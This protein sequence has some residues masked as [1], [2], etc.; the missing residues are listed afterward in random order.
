LL[1][2]PEKKV[3]RDQFLELSLALSSSGDGVYVEIFEWYSQQA[4][5]QWSEATTQTKESAAFWKAKKA[6]LLKPN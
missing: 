6:S 1:Q 2:N 5:V 3:Y 4:T